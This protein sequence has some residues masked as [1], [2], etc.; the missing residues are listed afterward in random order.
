MF[1]IYVNN[2]RYRITE[3][4]NSERDKWIKFLDTDT[5]LLI[6][7]YTM[8]W[9]MVERNV[10][11]KSFNK[12]EKTD[13]CIE[14]MLEKE[15]IEDDINHIWGLFMEFNKRY[16]YIDELYR[17]FDFIKSRITLE[18]VTHLYNSDSIKDKIK[19]L[20]YSCYRVRCNLFHGPK[21]IY[22]LDDQKILFLAMNELLSLICIVYRI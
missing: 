14:R 3:N 17:S 21:S 20:I 16:G 1:E 5:Q 7:D 12:S 9:N 4:Y 2:D 18:E 10:Y 11:N 8:M 13:K 6:L 22:N 19:L 15:N